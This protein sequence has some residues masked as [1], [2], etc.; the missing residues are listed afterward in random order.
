MCR[1]ILGFL[2]FLNEK[3]VLNIVH[4]D[5]YR[6]H[7]VDAYLLIIIPNTKTGIRSFRHAPASLL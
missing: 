1:F 6:P 3:L 5:T 2:S 4:G 7:A